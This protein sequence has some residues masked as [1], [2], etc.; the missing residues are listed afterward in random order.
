[1]TGERRSVAASDL[2]SGMLTVMF[3]DLEESTLRWEIDDSEM[4]RVMNVHD[5][6]LDQVVRSHDGVVF[7]STGDGI[8]AVF[9]SP[10]RAIDAAVLIQ[11]QL[12]AVPWRRDR[13]R[14]R[15]GLHLG[16]I[17]P[18]RGD[19]Y[20]AD[21]NRAARIMDV[22][23]GDQIAISDALAEFVEPERR[24]ACG[25]HEL[26]GIGTEN[27]HLVHDA[28]LIDDQRPLRA[29]TVRPAQQL[30][31]AVSL[32]VG[33]QREI[34]EIAELVRS[35]RLVTVVG[36]GGVGKTHVGL[37]VG[38]V[39]EQ[40][41]SDGAVFVDLGSIRHGDDVAPA[42]A[43]A[44]GARLQPG[45]DLLGSIAHYVEGRELLV[46]LDNCEH[47]IDAVADVISRLLESA[48][49]AV[50]ATSRS[51]FTT[52]H[53][54]VYP[55]GP[56][57][58]D[59]GIDLFI[60]RA[61]SRDPRLGST[62][63][64]PDAVARICSAV[65]GIPLGIELAAAWVRV[66][67]LDDLA[68]RLERS[69]DLSGRPAE[70]TQRPDVGLRQETLRSTIEWSYLQL[71]EREALLFDRI[72]VF[73][74][75]FSIDAAETVCSDADLAA[76]EIA[77]V[78]MALVDASVVS[79]EHVDGGRRFSLLRPLQMFGAD[80]LERRS[81][82]DEMSRCHAEYYAASVAH[83][84]RRLVSEHERDVWLFFDVEWS[85]IREAFA[86]LRAAGRP[87][88]AAQLLLDL[89]WYATLSLRSEAFG[90]AD[91][92]LA[93]TE[94][95]T[96]ESPSSLLGLRALHKY[97]IVDVDSRADAEQGL[98]LDPTDPEGFCRIA[99]GAVW[100]NNQ[101]AAHESA[102]WTN[103]W[104]G[105][106]TPK[107]PTM[108]R[109]WAHGMRAFHL[110]VHEPTSSELLDHVAIIDGIAADTASIS[111][112]V[113]AHWVSGMRLV[114]VALESGS[115]TDLAAGLREWREGRERAR[116]LSDIHL[117]DYLIT[118]IELH[119][120]A[121]DGVLGDALRLSRDALRRA[122]SHHYVAGTSHLFGVTAIVLARTGRADLG[123]RLLPVML[124]NGHPPRQNAID[125]V[126]ASSPGDGVEPT[127]VLSIHEAGHLADIAL[128][129]A[130]GDRA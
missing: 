56:L 89:G 30:P 39:L 101:Q 33:R 42:V 66:L 72:S 128:S 109:L 106:L 86:R 99:L 69:L 104:I 45:R 38:R 127:D 4:R 68:D 36:V 32:S 23:N 35:K 8:G 11:R 129:E 40:I 7:K 91:D 15:I 122:R 43:A 87:N 96:L 64:Q 103:E 74:G 65:G 57:C 100:V 10:T 59:D 124:A 73:M 47:V 16:D 28:A 75:G 22:A 93:S 95:S 71:D 19:Y 67:S 77:S 13:P 44:L 78:L 116:S 126:N 49:V 54:Q 63:A 17:G 3:T 84:G 61:G 105:S 83:A 85:N 46:L 18:T 14:V 120:T 119:V 1:M 51:S 110:C 48:D 113:L 25:V 94:S 79:V 108:S 118:S 70:Q 111:A 21:V 41:F 88:A 53:E 24:S 117:L 82:V 121:A 80:N 37:A 97:F 90:W 81:G 125:A 102:L 107:S 55:L 98:S 60:D 112:R 76:D 50:L 29:L 26:R 2:P 114:S 123:R 58:G 115:S 9:P 62:N 20:G 12:Q 5:D 6:V 130:I 92:L 34:D 52:A 31:S 27:V